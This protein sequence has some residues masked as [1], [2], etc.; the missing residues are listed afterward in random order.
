MHT[1]NVYPY[2]YYMHTYN[3]YPYMYYT[4]VYRCMCREI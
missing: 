3:V 4:H 1:Y 2:M